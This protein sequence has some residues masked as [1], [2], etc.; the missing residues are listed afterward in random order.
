M[1]LS[2][3][4]LLL[5][6][7]A[8]AR[9][10][11]EAGV[12]VAC[13][14]PGTPST[15]ILEAL[16]AF[17]EVDA[18]WSVN[19]KVS[20]EVAF[21][22]SLAGARSMV[23]MKHVGLNVAADPMFTTSYV[24]A[25][26]GLVI[27]VADDPGMHSS[28]NEQ[29]SR[30]YARAAKLPMLE[31]SDAAEALAFT[32]QAFG[33]SEQFDTPMLIRSVTRLSHSRGVVTLGEREERP[34]PG[35]FDHDP[36]RYVMM[37]AYARKRH[38]VVEDRLRRLA[39]FAETSALNSLE[40]GDRGLGFITSGMAYQYLREVFPHASF[41]KL[42]LVWPLPINLISE[43]CRGVAKVHVVEEL[44]PFLETEV[45]ALGHDV[46]QL[47]LSRCGELDPD[48]LREIFGLQAPNE[49]IQL[50]VDL[51]SRPPVLCPGCPHRGVYYALREMG[52]TV[53]GDIGCYALGALPPLTAMHT[54]LC[55]GASITMAFGVEKALRDPTHRVAAVIG[56]STFAHSGITGLLDVIYNRGHTL[57]VIVDNRTTAM[58]GFQENPSSGYTAKGE[59]TV[60]LDFAK[61]GEALGLPPENIA[62]VSPRDL[63]M[64]EAELHRLDGQSGPA[65]LVALEPCVLHR[66]TTSLGS[67]W[68]VD[69]ELC[70]SC[71]ACL[72]LGCPAIVRGE[73]ADYE[74]DTVSIDAFLCVHCGFCR[75]VCP[76][77]AIVGPEP[78]LDTSGTVEES[79]A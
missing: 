15:E 14:Y 8:I 59:H 57:T 36:P 78:E 37:P 45:R 52:F 54:N 38:V 23:S 34:Q 31:P 74:P 25:P 42:G 64:L 77:G 48:L 69:S 11:W 43:F 33:L 32:R 73:S 1:C 16:T 76:V 35:G 65:L 56:D 22:A 41:L 13:A 19:E 53:T 62:V 60:A 50:S 63:V 7:E 66:R 46:G 17:P 67:A 70:I 12:R 49:P 20:L 58:T 39:T 6:N 61:L 9:G 4:R 47:P 40:W 55:M 21:G 71:G 75:Q 26:G 18:E 51:P 10:A 28:Q 44:D 24:G 3:K 2:E 79:N 72:D 5:G 30:H 27:V 68:E 29:D